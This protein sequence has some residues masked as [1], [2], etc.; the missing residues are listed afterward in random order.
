MGARSPAN[1]RDRGTKANRVESEPKA[2]AQAPPRIMQRAAP[3]G[4][5]STADPSQAATPE[6]AASSSQGRSFYTKATSGTSGIAATILG[7]LGIPKSASGQKEK[8]S[9]KMQQSGN[10]SGAAPAMA[11]ASTRARCDFC[12]ATVTDM[13]GCSNQADQCWYCWNCWENYYAS[14]RR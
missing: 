3:D 4:H 12:G 10:K 2:T 13:D 8:K 1:G 9:N 6:Q 7:Q 5:S 11:A 14:M